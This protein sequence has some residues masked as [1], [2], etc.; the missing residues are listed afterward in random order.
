M[1]ITLPQRIKIMEANEFAIKMH[2]GQMYGEGLPYHYHLTDVWILCSN[3]DYETQI[4]ALLHDVIED[5]EATEETVADKF[6]IKMGEMCSMISDEPGAN[7]KIRKEATHKKL[8]ALD[9]EVNKDIRVLVVKTADRLA[10][11]RRSVLD[12]NRGL[13]KMYIREYPEFHKAVYRNGLVENMWS[14]LFNIYHEYK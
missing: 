14:E 4:L 3:Y 11:M 1:N 12:N 8:A 10:N 2:K 6:G 7:R 5:T 13:I 9:D